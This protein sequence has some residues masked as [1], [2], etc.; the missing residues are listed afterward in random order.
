MTVNHAPLPYELWAGCAEN[1]GYP[2]PDAQL[3]AYRRYCIHYWMADFFARYFD[4]F[5]YPGDPK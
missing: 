4:Y 1:S 3:E 5:G 2:T